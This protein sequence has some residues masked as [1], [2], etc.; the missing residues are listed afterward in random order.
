MTGALLSFSAMAVSVRVLAGALGV[1]EILAVRAGFGSIVMAPWP[2]CI[3]S[4]ERRFSRQLP[5][6]FFR[7]TVHLGRSTSGR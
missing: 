3:P 7:N 5:L 4:C 1:S 6:R 2:P